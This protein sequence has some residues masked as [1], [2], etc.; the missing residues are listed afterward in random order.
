MVW[1]Y[2]FIIIINGVYQ[3]KNPKLSDNHKK[4]C[5]INKHTLQVDKV[6]RKFIDQIIKPVDCRV[7]CCSIISV[8]YL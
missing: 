7:L 3:Y 6:N 4:T 5:Y 8:L 2:I 1:C